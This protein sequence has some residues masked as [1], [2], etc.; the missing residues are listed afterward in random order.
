M[1]EWKP[2]ATAPKDGTSVLLRDGNDDNLD[3]IVVGFYGIDGESEDTEKMWRV[4]WNHEP[5]EDAEMWAPI[6]PLASDDRN[7]GD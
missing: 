7:T 5:F 2:I 4:K 1:T 3:F 6:P